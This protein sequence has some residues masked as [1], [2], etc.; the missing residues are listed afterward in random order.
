MSIHRDKWLISEGYISTNVEL[1]KKLDQMNTAILHHN[2]S[3]TDDGHIRGNMQFKTLKK[4]DNVATRHSK[5]SDAHR[6]LKYDIR[7]V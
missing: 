1:Q 2:S 5:E 6:M 4:L 7:S 3:N